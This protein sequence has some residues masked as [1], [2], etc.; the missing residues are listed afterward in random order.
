[1]RKFH[2]KVSIKVYFIAGMWEEDR[3]KRFTQSC[4]TLCDP[5][6]CSLPGSSV[7]GLLQARILEWVAIPF[8]RGSPQPRDQTWVSHTAGRL[9]SEPPGKPWNVRMIIY[10]WLCYFNA[11]AWLQVTEPWRMCWAFV[12]RG[13]F[14]IFCHLCHVSPCPTSLNFLTLAWNIFDYYLAVC[15]NIYCKLFCIFALILQV[16]S[17]EGR[18]SRLLNHR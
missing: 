1:M 12:W 4:L 17:T 8:S 14:L 18:N 13:S 10:W 3:K 7:H 6:D 16:D 15:L 11:E 9:L 5:T 2:S